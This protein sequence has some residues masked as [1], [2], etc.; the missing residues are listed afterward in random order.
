MSL[1]GRTAVVTGGSR[2][3]GR[4]IVLSLARAGADVAIGYRW[5]R[6]PCGGR[7]HQW[8]LGRGGASWTR[9][10]PRRSSVPSTQCHAC[11]AAGGVAS[12]IS[13]R[14]APIALT[15][16]PGCPRSMRRKRE[17]SRSRSPL[18]GRW[19]LVSEEAEF[20]TGA[21]TDSHSR[22]RASVVLSATRS[23]ERVEDFPDLELSRCFQHEF[24][25]SS[26]GRCSSHRP[27]HAIPR[28]FDENSRLSHLQ[29][30]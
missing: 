12:S 28:R 5:T 9:I 19:V 4:S 24:S 26:F 20:V 18:P 17:S 6:R 29:Y 25:I 7:W 22:M 8:T 15:G 1:A 2:R 16:P 3:I 30:R 14:R 21:A 11:A 23:V 10:S 27:T 13:A